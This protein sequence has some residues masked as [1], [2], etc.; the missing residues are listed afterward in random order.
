MV[1]VNSNAARQLLHTLC[2]Q[3]L[4]ANEFEELLDLC[5]AMFPELKVLLQELCETT[6]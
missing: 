3:G 2:D 4:S 1:P 6:G 5:D